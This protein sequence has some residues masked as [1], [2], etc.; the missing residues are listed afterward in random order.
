MSFVAGLLALV[1]AVVWIAYLAL[2]VSA[3]ADPSAGVLAAWGASTPVMVAF[4]AAGL[5]VID[6]FGT[7]R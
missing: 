2:A 6:R 4:A 1:L 7:S 3:V 5:W